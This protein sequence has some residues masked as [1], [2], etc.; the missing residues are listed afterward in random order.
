MWLNFYLVPFL[1]HPS[2]E[3]IPVGFNC[4]LVYE[5]TSLCVVRFPLGA[6]FNSLGAWCHCWPPQFPPS[7]FW[8]ISSYISSLMGPTHDWN[9]QINFDGGPMI[10]LVYLHTSPNTPTGPT[11]QP[12]FWLAPQEVGLPS[13]GAPIYPNG[14]TRLSCVCLFGGLKFLSPSLLGNVTN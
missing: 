2:H 5:L 12:C 3:A 1:V 8:C 4:H 7:H 6:F 10:A 11:Q 9:C 14:P 13:S